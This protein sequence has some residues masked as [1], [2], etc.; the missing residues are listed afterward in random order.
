MKKQTFFWIIGSFV[1]R[2]FMT[3]G[4]DYHNCYLEGSDP[5]R[6]ERFDSYREARS[7]M[8][9]DD[10]AKT[11]VAKHGGHQW[12]RPLKCQVACVVYPPK[13]R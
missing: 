7:Y 10:A 12:I 5:M 11:W 3:W 1:A 9:H 8:A 2:A 6:T 4:G 13:R